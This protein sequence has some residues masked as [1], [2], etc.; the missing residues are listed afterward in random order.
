[1]N[2]P[3]GGTIDPAS[4]TYTYFLTAANGAQHEVPSTTDLSAVTARVLVVGHY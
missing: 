3:T 1:V 4:G 2:N